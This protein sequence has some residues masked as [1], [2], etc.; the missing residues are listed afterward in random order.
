MKAL[1]IMCPSSVTDKSLRKLEHYYGI[2]F[3]RGASNGGGDN[4]YHA[5]IGD[6]ELLK[7]LTFHNLIEIALVKNASKQVTINQTN[8]NKTTEGASVSL[9]GADGSD[10]M[11]TFPTLYAILGG[12]NSVYERYIISDEPFSYDG[13]EAEE[14]HAYGETPDF[15]VIVGN[16]ARSI[17][18]PSLAGTQG[19]T[20]LA[21]ISAAGDYVNANGYPTCN[22]S[23]YGFEQAARSKNANVQVNIPYANASALDL[24]LIMALLYIECRTKNLNSVFGHGISCNVAP[25]ASTWGKVSGCRIKNGENWVYLTFSGSVYIAGSAVSMWSAINGQSPLLKMFEA[26]RAISDGGELEGVTNADGEAIQGL[27]DGVM[28]GIWTKT[29][30]AKLTC[31]LTSG[32]EVAERDVEVVLRTPVWRGRSRMWGNIWQHLSG[33]DVLNYKDADGMVHNDLYRAKSIADMTTDSDEANKDSANGYAFVGKY[34]KI[35]DLGNK[36]G[37]MMESL[38]TL[39]GRTVLSAVKTGA[40]IN[41]YESAYTYLDGT[42]TEGKYRR[43]TAGFF[44]GDA[45]HST[46]GLRFCYAFVVPSYSSS[47][48]GSGFR[49]EL[50]A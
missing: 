21:N 23:R 40:A 10:V 4:G 37:W 35:G 9:A 24:E 45:Y 33:Y 13:D 3:E 27:S 16:V 17:Y 11:Q 30:T 26:Q 8:W 29:F 18:N 1:R 46:D 12:T 43:K 5:M 25:N 31:A 15:E 44:G 14:I 38:S 2:E 28:T 48:F 20:R 39:K 22:K 32:G 42:A 50:S 49:V 19:A 36:S 47:N 6:E 7:N 41:N 34:E